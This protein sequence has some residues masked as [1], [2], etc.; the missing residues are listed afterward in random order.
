MCACAHF[1]K[2]A[3]VRIAVADVATSVC[4]YT[5]ICIIMKP[6]SPVLRPSARS[7]VCE[8]ELIIRPDRWGVF[9]RYRDALMVERVCMCVFML[10]GHYFGC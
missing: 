6:P 5:S 8:G 4:S 9:P 2:S 3:C 7:V 10:G 1:C